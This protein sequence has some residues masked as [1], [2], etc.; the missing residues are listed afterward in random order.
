MLE[1]KIAADVPISEDI[2]KEYEA[3]PIVLKGKPVK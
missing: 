2:T 1:A 3:R